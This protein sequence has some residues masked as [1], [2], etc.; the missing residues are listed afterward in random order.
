[1]IK[2]R[3]TAP[4]AVTCLNKALPEEMLFVLLARDVCAPAAIR[5]WVEARIVAGL[6][7]RD[8]VQIFEALQCAVYM[9]KQRPNIRPPVK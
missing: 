8:D 4:G 2:E 6:N 5:A 3:E 7:A 9:E 1:M